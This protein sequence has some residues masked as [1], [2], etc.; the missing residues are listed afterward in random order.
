VNYLGVIPKESRSFFFTYFFPWWQLWVSILNCVTIVF[1][2]IVSV[3]RLLLDML[4][5]R[6]VSTA[7][8]T[9]NSKYYRI[10]SLTP[11]SR[12]PQD[13]C[14]F[15]RNTILHIYVSSIRTTCIHNRV[16][17]EGRQGRINACKVRSTWKTQWDETVCW[18]R[19]GRESE[20]LQ[21]HLYQI[22]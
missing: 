1:F 4:I 17:L 15:F 16:L 14:L 2:Q 19:R 9:R 21:Y 11:H 6:Y 5:W 8:G 20:R 13:L 12:L 18:S 3:Q 7:T 22:P 10:P